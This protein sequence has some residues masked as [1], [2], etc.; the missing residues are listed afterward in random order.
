[1]KNTKNLKEYNFMF[2]LA[3]SFEKKYINYQKAR[4]GLLL[5]TSLLDVLWL[6][7]LGWGKAIILNITVFFSTMTLLFLNPGVS[8][9]NKFIAVLVNIWTTLGILVLLASTWST[10]T[11]NLH[12]VILFC[13]IFPCTLHESK[14]N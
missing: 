7:S 10:L 13:G 14:S 2:N 11:T 6:I 12:L 9:T 1:M 4:C 5:A 3:Y 8:K